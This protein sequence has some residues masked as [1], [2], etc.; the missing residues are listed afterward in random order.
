MGRASTAAID[1]DEYDGTVGGG[2][3]NEKVAGGAI[4]SLVCRFMETGLT[5][6]HRLQQFVRY[7]VRQT[8]RL[9]EHMEH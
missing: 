1:C 2:A 3:D 4:G 5:G 6:P 9:V 7:E 8:G